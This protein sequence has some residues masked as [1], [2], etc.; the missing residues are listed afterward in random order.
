MKINETIKEHRT[1][2]GLTQSYIADQIG[3]SVQ[4]VSKWEK[5]TS[6]PDIILLPML[7]RLLK[8][9]VNTLFN[10]ND[11]LTE[12][13]INQFLV[14]EMIDASDKKTIDDVFHIGMNKIK[15]YP[16]CEP[17]AVAV[18]QYLESLL[19]LYDMPQ[20]EAYQKQL[21]TLFD[22]LA[23]SEN[24]EIRNQIVAARVPVLIASKKYLIAQQL[25]DQ[26]PNKVL[27]KRVLQG[28]LLY[29]EGKF[30]EME[31]VAAEKLFETVGDLCMLLYGLTLNSYKT[32][33]MELGAFFEES[34]VTCMETFQ[35]DSHILFEAR[36]KMAL[37]KK[38]DEAAMALLEQSLQTMKVIIKPDASDTHPYSKLVNKYLQEKL[39]DIDNL[40][41][42][43]NMLNLVEAKWWEEF[44]QE[45]KYAPLR[46]MPAYQKLKTD[47][48]KKIGEKA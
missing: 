4:A 38:D 24:L 31:Q 20:K 22:R 8:T 26:L 14:Q 10:F 19:G 35:V 15:E 3:V 13:E 27:D 34:F 12:K 33:Q 2:L 16:N 30:E 29:Q 11:Q 45:E 17:L 25:L 40:H 23:K 18:V 9:D 44:E 39:G 36:M 21:D 47:F 42:D 32:N 7:A 6:H 41:V 37:E 5:G 43:E 1:K 28:E 46:T 48:E